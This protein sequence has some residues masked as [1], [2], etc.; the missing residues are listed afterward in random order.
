MTFPIQNLHAFLVG[1]QIRLILAVFFAGL[2][3]ICVLTVV[4]NLKVLRI[5]KSR[6]GKG[7]TRARFIESFQRLGVPDEIPAAVFDYYTS[8]GI[9]K[10][11]PLAPDDAYSEVLCDDEGDIEEDALALV[12]RLEMRLLPENTLR[13]YGN[14]PFA[15]VRDM[16][17][18]LDWIR[19]RQSTRS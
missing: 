18:W 19:Q 7:F 3:I 11:F 2:L 6:Q 1:T 10:G 8:S 15:T 12:E 9:W 14:K 5:R 13:E 16:V 17:L 4:K